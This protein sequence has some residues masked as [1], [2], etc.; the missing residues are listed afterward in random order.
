LRPQ[1]F[2]AIQLGEIDRRTPTDPVSRGRINDARRRFHSAW[3]TA[4]D[5]R[6]RRW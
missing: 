1:D 5:A 6:K 4:R 2:Y 3:V